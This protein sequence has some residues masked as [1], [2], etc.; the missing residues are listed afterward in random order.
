M[1]D[2]PFLRELDVKLKPAMLIAEGWR[3]IMKN[4]LEAPPV[5]EPPKERILPKFEAQLAARQPIGWTFRRGGASMATGLADPLG[6]ARVVCLMLAKAQ[7]LGLTI[8]YSSNFDELGEVRFA[9]R[10]DRVSPMFDPT[11]SQLDDDRAF[12]I[13]AFDADG[14][15]ISLQA[16]R[17]DIVHPSLAEWAL[18]WMAGLY[19]K[20][21]E[22]V[23]PSALQPPAHSRSRL[24][25][26]ALVYHGEMWTEKTFKKREW[27]D[28][29]PKLGMFTAHIKWQPD[30]LW[31][32][33][34]K[35]FATHGYVARSGYA[36]QERGFLQWEWEPQGADNIEWLIIAERSHLEFLIDEEVSRLP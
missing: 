15:P 9:A 26:G 30:A 2:Y 21:K 16:F 22:L 7:E 6:L 32:L 31:A 4:L 8:R 23:L 28:L 33:T 18:G 24:L 17:L 25:K 36:H 34:G 1:V 14:R 35:S 29:F 12:W 19:I 27:F 20:R 3:P 5:M 11:V 13:G 10:G